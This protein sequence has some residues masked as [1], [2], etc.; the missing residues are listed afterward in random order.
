MLLTPRISPD[1]FVHVPPQ[2]S[3]NKSSRPQ[4]DTKGTTRLVFFLT[5]NPGLLSY[6]HEYLALLA[7]S[8]EGQDYVIVGLSLGGF[9]DDELD[10]AD[11]ELL[12]PDAVA[13]KRSAKRR[14]EEQAWWSLSE[15]VEL[16]VARI[17]DVVRRLQR[18]VKVTLMG[19]SVGS[20]LAFEVVRSAHERAGRLSEPTEDASGVLGVGSVATPTPTWRVEACVLL[21]PT[22]MHLAQSPSGIK[23]APLLATVSFLPWLLQLAA[24]G[25]TWALSEGSTRWLIARFMGLG[26]ELDGVTTT[27]RFLQSAGGVR[28]AVEMAKQELVSIGTDDWGPEVWGNA[29][30]VNNGEW[31]GEGGPQ[32]YFLF[33]KTDHWVADKTRDEIRRTRGRKDGRGTVHVDEKSGL[34]HAWCLKQN[35]AVS[36]YVE[37]WLGQI[38]R[39]DAS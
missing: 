26:P 31:A 24:S 29:D 39:Q 4:D 13:A 30:A 14:S 6:Y 5:G 16:A 8:D 1:A 28:Q 10:E 32:L 11:E 36:E 15:Q 9:E 25:M 34:V 20:Y 17:D 22:I 19:H 35:R 12:F 2:L 38:R 21:A 23:A 3:T 37:P 33:A 18:D 7:A 27:T